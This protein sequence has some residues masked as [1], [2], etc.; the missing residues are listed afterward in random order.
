MDDALDRQSTGLRPQLDRDELRS[1]V[2]EEQIEL[3]ERDKR[4]LSVVVKGISFSSVDSFKTT[5]D[6][7]TDSL[8]NTKVDVTD[9]A[10][11]TPGLVRLNITNKD[12]RLQLLTSAPK[13]KNHQDYSRIYISRDLTY[14]Q[15]AEL[16][17]RRQ[18]SGPPPASHPLTGANA[19]AL[20]S[21]VQ[22]PPP[23]RSLPSTAPLTS[24]IPLLTA[25]GSG[26]TPIS[27]SDPIPSSQSP[28]SQSTNLPSSHNVP[29]SSPASPPNVMDTSSAF[30]NALNVFSSPANGQVVGNRVSGSPNAEGAASSGTT[31]EG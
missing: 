14:R 22:Q 8:I 13:L 29:S 12:L 21:S 30:R 2:R 24:A 19:V 3:R 9:I 1:I 5:F 7:I 10:P 16:K 31:T 20:A 17:A 28:P 18:R 4:K 25:G 15:R 11:V 6:K 26:S 23:V 27:Q